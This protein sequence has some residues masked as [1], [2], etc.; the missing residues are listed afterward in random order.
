[1][2]D[3]LLNAKPCFPAN[4]LLSHWPRIAAVVALSPSLKDFGTLI[5]DKMIINLVL[6]LSF[7]RNVLSNPRV[8]ESFRLGRADRLPLDA[9]GGAEPFREKNVEPPNAMAFVSVHREHERW[10]CSAK[11]VG[12]VPSKRKND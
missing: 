9:V 10:L 3:Q 5:I 6:F 1:M 4:P 8:M 2:A 7:F 11:G 12:G